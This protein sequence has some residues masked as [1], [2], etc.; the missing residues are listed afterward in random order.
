MYKKRCSSL[1]FIMLWHIVAFFGEFIEISMK[2]PIEWDH[3]ISIPPK[4][5]SLNYQKVNIE[6]RTILFIYKSKLKSHQG[7]TIKLFRIGPFNFDLICTVK[8]RNWNNT[9][10]YIHHCAYI[11][12]SKFSFL[13]ILG[14]V[15]ITFS[16]T[17][18]QKET[19]F[20]ELSCNKKMKIMMIKNEMKF[21]I[22]RSWAN[23]ILL[24]YFLYWKSSYK[25][26]VAWRSW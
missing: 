8:T 5:M 16:N 13:E 18:R 1:M 15:S 14:K 2:V 6:R 3:W 17:K 19:E 20:D 23:K 26:S 12:A 10:C 9:L 22:W 11:N 24:I 4:I 25:S 21:S 7:Q